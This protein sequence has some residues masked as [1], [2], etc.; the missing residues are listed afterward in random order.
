MVAELSEWKTASSLYNRACY[1]S[2]R[3]GMKED[4]PSKKELDRAEEL[5]NEAVEIQ[6]NL[7]RFARIDPCLRNLKEKVEATH[8]LREEKKKAG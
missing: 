5:L 8:W 3:N 4:G 2:V 1:Y 7:R 6:E